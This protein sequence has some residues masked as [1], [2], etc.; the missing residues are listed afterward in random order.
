MSDELDDRM[1]AIARAAG[2]KRVECMEC[3]H[4]LEAYTR[5]SQVEDLAPEGGWR[6]KD[7]GGEVARAKQGEYVS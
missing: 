7:C 6:C 2:L 3:G 4:A 5:D 1:R